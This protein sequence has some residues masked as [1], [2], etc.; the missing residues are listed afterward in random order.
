[1][2]DQRLS[3]EE[4]CEKLT[5]DFIAET[6]PMPARIPRFDDEVLGLS[7]FRTF[8]GEGADFAHLTIPR[9]F[10]A[11]SEFNDVSFRN[12]DLSESCL[13]WN[14]FV[15]VD[16]TGADLGAADL[17]SSVYQGV[18]F[19]AANLQG[20]DLRRSSFEGCSF[21]NARL[22]GAI[23]SRSQKS[24]LSLSAEQSRVVDW[25]WRAGPEPD[26]G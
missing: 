2:A 18:T 26:G 7:F 22:D 5:P 14:D 9:T 6:P 10:A 19:D 8:I 15:D 24:D 13:C 21:A 20:A 12:T 4:S 25:R 16:F 1:M 3:Y 17:R 23:A 11:R